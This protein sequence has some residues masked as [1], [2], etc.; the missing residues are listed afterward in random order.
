MSAAVYKVIPFLLEDGSRKQQFL[1]KLN[2]ATESFRIESGTIRRSIFFGKKTFN[3]L[4]QFLRNEYGIPLGNIH[5]D[6]NR[7]MKGSATTADNQQFR[8]S[9]EQAAHIS[10]VLE[11]QNNPLH[12]ITATLTGNLSDT[13]EL[14]KL[15]ALIPSILA[16]MIYSKDEVA[17]A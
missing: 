12:K 8:F 14:T 7:M 6:D 5:Y 4:F 13:R 11:S 9:I 15:T 17:V 2:A 1:L 10:V 3:R 16:A